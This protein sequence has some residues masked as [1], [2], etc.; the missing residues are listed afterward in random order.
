MNKTDR[1]QGWLKRLRSRFRRHVR[2]DLRNK[3]KLNSK[4]GCGPVQ[5]LGKDRHEAC[6]MGDEF[7]AIHRDKSGKILDYYDS[8]FHRHKSIVNVGLPLAASLL[9]GLGAAAFTYGG[10]GTG[11]TAVTTSDTKLETQISRLNCTPTRVTTTVTNDTLQQDIIFSH[12]TDA[13]LTGTAV[14]VTETGV[15]DASGTTDNAMLWR[16][17]FGAITV[18]W[19]NNDSL[20]MILKTQMKQGS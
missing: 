9:G 18:N 12:A 11:T 1:F 16:Q 14:A 13:G 10:I 15:F 17:V 8:R 3:G 19:D 4:A 7:I 2:D 6:G 5:T 20:E